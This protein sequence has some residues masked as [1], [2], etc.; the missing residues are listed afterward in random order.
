MRLVSSARSTTSKQKPAGVPSFATFISFQ[1]KLLTPHAAVTRRLITFI[2]KMRLEKT[3]RI[4][5]NS[6][7][8]IIPESDLHNFSFHSRSPAMKLFLCNFC[9]AGARRG[10]DQVGAVGRR[11]TQRQAPRLPPRRARAVNTNFISSFIISPLNYPLQ[12]GGPSK[13]FSKSLN[14]QLTRHKD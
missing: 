10:N 3:K 1:E 9:V 7:M 12:R 5:R 8:G 6:A 13:Y 11:R 2:G 14:V 4:S